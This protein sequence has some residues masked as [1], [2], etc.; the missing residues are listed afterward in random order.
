M[1]D[2]SSTQRN[3]TRRLLANSY[4]AL[5]CQQLDLSRRHKRVP[6]KVPKAR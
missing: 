4:Q 2:D 5:V 6:E 1:G 3:W